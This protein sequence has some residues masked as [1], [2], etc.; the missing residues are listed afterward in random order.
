MRVLH[1]LLIF[2]EDKL[3]KLCQGTGFSHIVP[4]LSP[5]GVARTSLEKELDTAVKKNIHKFSEGDRIER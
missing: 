2:I 1:P 5:I 3:E 4:A